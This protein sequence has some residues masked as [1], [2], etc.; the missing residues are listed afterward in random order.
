MNRLNIEPAVWELYT[1]IQERGP[2]YCAKKCVDLLDECEEY[3]LKHVSKDDWHSLRTFEGRNGA[4]PATFATTVIVNLVLSCLR[5]IKKVVSYEEYH[6]HYSNIPIFQLL[7]YDE[8]NSAVEQ[9]DEMERLIILLFYYDG[10]SA[11][12]IAIM[13]NYSTTQLNTIINEKFH[14][15]AKEMNTTTENM[16]NIMNLAPKKLASYKGNTSKQIHKKIE[17]AKSKLKTILEGHV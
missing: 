6:D 16:I 12:E 4:A 1:I 15:L 2:K 13:L 7:M 11:D 14:Y 3:I 5:S 10:Y 8:V 9:L 17:N